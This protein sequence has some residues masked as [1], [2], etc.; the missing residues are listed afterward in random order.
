MVSGIEE[1]NAIYAIEGHVSSGGFVK[2]HFSHD[3]GGLCNERLSCA[4]LCIV[5]WI[6]GVDAIHYQP[7]DARGVFN[8]GGPLDHVYVKICIGFDIHC[9]VG[10]ILKVE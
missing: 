7:L 9:N 4:L 10:Y 3:F 1:F 5:R 8:G 2:Q 6:I